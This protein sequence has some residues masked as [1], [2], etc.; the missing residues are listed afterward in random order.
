M[1][2]NVTIKCYY[3]DPYSIVGSLP[4]KVLKFRWN[5]VEEIMKHKELLYPENERIPRDEIEKILK[6]YARK[7]N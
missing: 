2:L 5:T 6:K 3:F 1:V 7:E 4:A